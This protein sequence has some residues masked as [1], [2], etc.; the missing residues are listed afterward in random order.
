MTVVEH[1]ASVVLGLYLSAFTLLLGFIILIDPDQICATWGPVPFF[2]VVS[3]IT[4]LFLF[5]TKILLHA[6][7]SEETN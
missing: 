3:S 6:R 1:P 4:I 7:I 2:L 5:T